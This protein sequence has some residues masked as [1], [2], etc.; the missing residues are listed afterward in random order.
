MDVIEFVNLHGH[1]R[2]TSSAYIKPQPEKGYYHVIL[3]ED[4]IDG[5]LSKIFKNRL[6]LSNGKLTNTLKKYWNMTY[7]DNR[8]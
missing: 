7:A 4:G 2:C 1:R 3:F 6:L 5:K 8:K